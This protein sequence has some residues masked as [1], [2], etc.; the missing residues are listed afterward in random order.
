MTDTSHSGQ[1]KIRRLLDSFEATGPD[2]THIILVFEPAQMS[3]RDLKVVFQRDGFDEGL[4][5]EAIIELLQTL[6]FLHSHAGVIHTGNSSF[7]CSCHSN[8][9]SS[10]LVLY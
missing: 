10:V 4:V 5:K 2:G 7:K 9:L 1:K 8:L 6:D 3:L